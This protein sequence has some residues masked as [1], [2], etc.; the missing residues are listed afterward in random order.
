MAKTITNKSWHS[1]ITIVISIVAFAAISWI[2]F[3]PDDVTGNVLRQHDVTQGIANGQEVKAFEATSGE[4]SRWTN[5]LFSGMPTFQITPSYE[6][7]S[8]LSWVNKVMGLGFPSPVNLVFIMMVGFFILMLSF[9]VKW[10]IAVMGA[11]AYAFSSYFFILIGAG[12]IWKYVTLAYIPPTIAGIVWAYRG[13]ILTGSAVAALFAAIQLAS[14]HVQMTYY[15]AFVIVAMALAYLATAIRNKTVKQWLTATGAL[16]VA[17]LLAVAANAPNLYSTLKYSKETMRGGHSEIASGNPSNASASGLDK[18]YITAWSYGKAETMTL[19]VPNVNGGATIKPEKGSNRF[20]P[21]T[22]TDMAKQMLNSGEISMQEYQFMSQF[23]QYFGN[24]P[25]T[26]G[27]VYVGAL[28]FALFVLGCVT[29]KGHMKWALLAVTIFSILLAWGRNMMWLT[30]LMIDYFPMYNKFRT[31]ASILV[32]AEFTMPLLAM[33]TLQQMFTTPRWWQEHRRAFFGTMGACLAICLFIYFVPTV[34]SIY[35]D[36][37][38][39]QLVSAGLLQQYP[40]LFMA[41]ESIRKSMISAD[42]LRSLIFLVLGGV[43]LWAYLMDKVQARYAALATAIILFADL[44][45]VNKRYLNTDSFTAPMGTVESFEPRAVDRQ[46]LADTAQNYRVFDIAN[47]SEAMPSYFHKCIGGYHAAKLT[48]YQD[49][50]DHQI[51]KGNPEVINMLNTKY[52]IQSDSVVMINP[53]ALGNAWFVD[54]LS[55]VDGAAAEMGALNNLHTATQAVA[56]SKFSSV[57]GN[58]KPKA[59]GDTIYETTYAPNALTYSATSQNGGVAVFSEIYFPWGWKA[60]I[61]GKEVEIGRVNYVLRALNI[62][63]GHHT[64]SFVFDPQTVRTADTVATIAIVLIYLSLLVALNV[65]IYR[66]MRKS[67]SENE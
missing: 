19:L 24:Q 18:D 49:L 23:P 50:I 3:Y 41:I 27:P 37:E 43:V 61:D 57:L 51:N 30:D 65:N 33:L 64:I 34:F 15:F 5:S 42:A 20:L 14:N 66:R 31:V 60:T 12:H 16:A 29:I 26:N 39:D 56:D 55:Y 6:S 9:D 58:A 21:L 13:R 53:D 40:S 28:I 17:A 48:R 25:M 47:F 44:F 45:T 8:L 1:I 59:A 10:Y 63:A 62:P 38:Y 32:I 46:I 2:Y 35:S 52:I 7:S 4:V 22:D 54:T 36:S 11:I 67:E